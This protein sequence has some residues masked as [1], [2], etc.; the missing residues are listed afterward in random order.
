MDTATTSPFGPLVAIADLGAGSSVGE[1]LSVLE[2]S[3]KERGLEHTVVRTGRR[4]EATRAAAEALRDGARYLV[5]VGDDHTVQDVV[6]GMFSDGRPLVPDAVLGMIPGRRG[7]DLAMSFGLPMEAERAVTHLG[8][9][10]T[11][12]LDVMKM[13]YV[14]LDGTRMTRYATNLAEVGLGGAMALILREREGNT[15]RFA[16]FW[17]AWLRSR[18]THV[19][20][21][22]DKKAWEGKAY[23]VV[24][25]NGQFTA[26]L[27]MSPR[28]F[29]GD[30]VL[31]AL[32]FCGPR[33]DAYT[34]LPRIY[35]HGDHVPDS[36]IHELRAK[37]RIAVDAE[38]ALPIVADG[39]PSGTTPA[40]FQVVPQQILLK[41]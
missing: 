10:N 30:G 25:G 9:A 4:G 11:Y 28:S 19:R 16:A 13:T 7:L 35:R 36:H 23:N 26:G 33:S 15:R 6:N 17:G 12:P 37:I 14:G 27:R 41:L 1:A 40:T 24:V 21:N 18:P 38:R 2:R 39:V 8:G 32:V 34:L 3:L 31:D 5:A 29:P 20:V 22:A